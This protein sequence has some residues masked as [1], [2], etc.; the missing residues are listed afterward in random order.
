MEKD[1]VGQEPLKRS[2]IGLIEAFLLFV[3]FLFLVDTAL[4]YFVS[5]SA[6]GKASEE[7]LLQTA[8]AIE[9]KAASIRETTEFLLL[10]AKS[11]AERDALDFSDP[12]GA[13]A[14]FMVHMKAHP[15]VTSVNFGDSA[16]NGYLLLRS[17]GKW[18][19][20]FKR[21]AEAGTVTWVSTDNL[22]K[23]L[24]RER[25]KDDYDPRVRPWYVNAAGSP[26]IFWSRPY[27]FRTTGDVGITASIA[28]DPG[29]GKSSGAVGADVMLKDISRFFSDL[30]RGNGDLSITLV[31]RE[32]EI[33]ASSEVGNFVENL[34]KASGELPRVTGG[35]FQVLAAAYRAF[36]NGGT[37]FLSF[38]SSGRKYYA[39]RRPF[40]FSPD[41]ALSMILMVPQDSFLSF[42]GSINRVRLIL[43]LVMVAVSGFFFAVRF[44]TPLRKLTRAVRTF[45]TD[46][47]EPPSPGNR[48]DEVGVL[49]SE[50]RGMAEKLS[51]K[52]RE[53]SRL[54]M[55]VEQTAE[56]IVVTDAAGTIEYVN[57]SF[58][59]VTGY[60]AEEAVGRNPRILK[61]GKQDEAFYRTLWRTLLRGEVWKGRFVNRK[62]DGT[63]YDEE[64]TIS[65][66]RN[67]AGKIVNFVAVKKDVTREVALEKQVRTAQ[68]M[69]SVGTL[70]GGIAHDFNNAL[71]G[72]LGFG[73]MLRLRVADRPE[74]LKDLDTIAQCAQQAAMLTRQLLTFARRQVIDPVNLDLNVVVRE[75]EKL[76]RKAAGEHI[77][78]ETSLVPH[79]PASRLDR[80]QVEQV[81]MNLCL[82][83]RDAMPTG[84]RLL[85][86]TAD[87]TVGGEYLE[88]HPYVTPGR[89]V[90]LTVTDTGIGMDEETVGKAFEPFFT[91]KAA[92]K[93][94][95]LGLSS[96]YGIVKQGGG[97]IHVYSEPGKGSCFKVYFPAVEAPADA[98]S[99]G[100]ARE[101][102]RGG[103]ETILVAED[104]ESLRKL[105]VRVLEGLGYTVLAARDGEEAVAIFRENPGI[106]LALLDVVMPGTGGKA[107]YDRMRE[108]NPRL[109]AIFMSGYSANA[110]HES[111]VL[112][113]GVPFLTKPYTLPALG[114][115]VREVLDD[116]G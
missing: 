76:V 56:A 80:G 93:G 73:E 87:V 82:N 100:P 25:R 22:G 75:M 4:Q 47:Y 50:F 79:L 106:S 55:A 42:F 10:Q 89:Y 74:A 15:H 3:G 8:V 31:S 115:K 53:L 39:L 17:E 86:E 9:N 27:V 1:R 5:A 59:R 108:E 104:E 65:P 109:K 30:K 13:N 81:L 69:E 116:P 43:Y 66:V 103:T 91:T 41:V 60:P 37:G 97:F 38:T 113:P 21:G 57:P 95:G 67:A 62:R 46:G 99:G 101:P 12:R 40:R 78:V 18:R 16:G 102:V 114:R 84:G 98:V 20:R 45:G 64:A 107:A 90:Q 49:V 19:N 48:K 24:S 26:D 88:A 52:Q 111:F 71:T 11:F 92:G 23:I 29:K 2:G 35:G 7:V 105:A 58:E 83:A 44:L 34:R 51:A 96:V 110:V 85:I 6:A 61:S 28:I 36:G 33:L 70:A 112:N 72:V 54:I 63:L 68:R 14:F 94:T 77:E 32:G